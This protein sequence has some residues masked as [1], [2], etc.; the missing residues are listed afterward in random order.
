MGD[1]PRANIYLFKEDA[2]LLKIS[3]M[4]A[5]TLSWPQYVGTMV[6]QE[7]RKDKAKYVVHRGTKFEVELCTIKSASL[8]TAPFYKAI[9][10]TN[11]V[12]TPFYRFVRRLMSVI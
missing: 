2:H 11:P 5:A 9:K 8:T 12:P 1:T 7:R 6:V 3:D 10:S 4:W